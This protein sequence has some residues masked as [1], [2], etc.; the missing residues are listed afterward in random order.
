[1]KGV[2]GGQCIVPGYY[3]FDF[4]W[5]NFFATQAKSA[6]KTPAA[7]GLEELVFCCLRKVSPAHQCS[8]G[9][10]YIVQECGW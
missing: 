4:G 7:R 3:L 2:K 6:I 10:W 1:M 9:V 8:A 5:R